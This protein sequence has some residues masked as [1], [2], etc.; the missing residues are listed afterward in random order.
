MSCSDGHYTAGNAKE[1]DEDMKDA[2]NNPGWK[3][4]TCGMVWAPWVAYCKKC[5]GEMDYY[6]SIGDIGKWSSG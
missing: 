2:T 3:C 4:P 6:S 1:F 5:A